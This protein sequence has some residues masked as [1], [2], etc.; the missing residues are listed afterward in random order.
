MSG[1]LGL[2]TTLNG[3]A[4]TTEAPVPITTPY[5]KGAPNSNG[6]QPTPKARATYLREF[7]IA[8]LDGTNNLLVR[9]NNSLKQVTL[10]PSQSLQLNKGLVYALSVASSASTVAWDAVGIAS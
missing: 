8:N 1:G 4:T 9:I 5:K 7:L 2:P 10:K 3:T 6:T